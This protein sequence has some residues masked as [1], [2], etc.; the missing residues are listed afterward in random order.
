MCRRFWKV[1]GGGAGWVEWGSV[2]LSLLG[3]FEWAS[4]NPKK[5]QNKAQK[6]LRKSGL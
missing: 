4:F 3:Q 5:I 1:A 6:C 2:L